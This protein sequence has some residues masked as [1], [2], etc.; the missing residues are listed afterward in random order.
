MFVCMYHAL[1]VRVVCD[2]CVLRVCLRC[3]YI[4]RKRMYVT[5]THA[6]VMCTYSYVCVYGM[7]VC[8]CA[9]EM[10][11]KCM[12]HALL[13]RVVCDICVLRVCLRCVYIGNVFM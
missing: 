3:I 4:Y 12:Y 6:Y 8:V 13:V 5:R 2:I 7:Y 11:V 1:L 9:C 10:Y